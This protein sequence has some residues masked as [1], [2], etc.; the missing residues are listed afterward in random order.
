MYNDGIVTSQSDFG[1]LGLV[2]HRWG[3]LSFGVHK[4][5][6]CTTETRVLVTYGQSSRLIPPLVMAPEW[7]PGGEPNCSPDH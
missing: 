3:P 2:L 6:L 7:R 5:P 1:D 4:Q